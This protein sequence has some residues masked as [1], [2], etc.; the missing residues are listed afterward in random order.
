MTRKRFASA[1]LMLLLFIAAAAA[2]EAPTPATPTDLACL[3]EHT[4]T[5]IYFFD[6]PSYTPVNADSHKV[7]GPATVETVC[8]D[9]GEVL[10]S[11]TVDSAEEIRSHSFKKG[12]CALC[13]YRLKKKTQEE[14]PTDAPGEYTV[15]APEDGETAGLLT[16]TLTTEDLFELESANVSVVLVRGE[17]G[18]AA[19]ALP[20]PSAPYASF[21]GWFTSSDFSGEGY[22][23]S[24]PLA[25]DQFG[26][27]TFY[28]KWTPTGAKIN[29]LG[30]GEG[31]LSGEY[32]DAY[33]F[34]ATSVKLPTTV[35]REGFLF[36]GWYTS[37]DLSPASRVDGF[38]YAISPTLTE[39]LN[40]YAAFTQTGAPVSYQTL[41]DLSG[42][43]TKFY[44]INAT[45][46]VTL[47][48][49]SIPGYTFLGWYT[50]ADFAGDALT[51]SYALPAD[52]AVD[53]GITFYAK[54]VGNVTID[55][56]TNGFTYDL[57]KKSENMTF[58]NSNGTARFAISKSGVSDLYF[59]VFGLTNRLGVYAVEFKISKPTEESAVLPITFRIHS[60]SGSAGST[61]RRSESHIFQTNSD[62]S[63]T[64]FNGDSAVVV[65]TV[66][67]T[68][69][70][71]TLLLDYASEA[72]KV[73]A[74][75][76]VDGVKMGEGTI[77]SGIMNYSDAVALYSEEGIEAYHYPDKF[78]VYAGSGSVGELLID[79]FYT[80]EGYLPTG[81][82][83][84]Y[85]TKYL[86]TFGN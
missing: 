86:Q 33:S 55:A 19:I 63:M 3:H 18:D 35:E 46:V 25:P 71:V 4:K 58:T 10:S 36:A 52:E 81:T 51:T 41:G 7:Y 39:E 17:T 77:N 30:I 78:Y 57:Q 85:N 75:C 22:K 54:F 16:L 62:G 43:Y 6:S 34:G 59:Q 38:T 69:Q 56:T 68:P 1:I 14:K 15:I 83:D 72:G 66:T 48:T 32:D 67:T 26:S 2:A 40:F 80:G 49:T 73:S 13:G 28:A 27:I 21:D 31:T 76:Y 42:S 8:L 79:D 60:K 37:S 29:Y 12:V 84:A 24:Y 64:L 53:S 47:P 61:P 70:T 50:S 45:S 20:T 82:G 65:G 5:T 23:D 44:P 11:E 74:V 9:C